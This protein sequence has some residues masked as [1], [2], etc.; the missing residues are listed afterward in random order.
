MTHSA[1]PYGCDRVSLILFGVKVRWVSKYEETHDDIRLRV[2]S[3]NSVHTMC[4]RVRAWLKQKTE[5]EFEV[6]K[7]V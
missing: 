4:V 2:C 5:K 6:R 1:A 7:G 3:N